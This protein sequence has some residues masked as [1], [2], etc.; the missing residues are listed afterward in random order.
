MRR[1]IILCDEANQLPLFQQEDLLHRFLELFNSRNTQ[2]VF[3]AGR[4]SWEDKFFLPS[5]FETSFELRGFSKRD[6]IVALLAQANSQIGFD[7]AAIDILW[8]EFCGRPRETVECCGDCY[9]EAVRSGAAFVSA[10]LAQFFCEKIKI[11][12]Q[13]HTER[14]RSL[15]RKFSKS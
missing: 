13:E 14:Q 4:A 6:H 1:F 15:G 12:E 7:D 9:E 8:R 3:I 10:N 5:C 2:F 11:R